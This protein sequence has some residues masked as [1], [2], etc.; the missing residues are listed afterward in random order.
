MRS[1]YSG[2]ILGSTW[3]PPSLFAAAR[4]I[5]FRVHLFSGPKTTQADPT[6]LHTNSLRIVSSFQRRLYR[7]GHISFFG[8]GAVNLMFYLTARFALS[9]STARDIASLGFI[10]GGL[11][12]P[13]VCFLVAHRAHCKNLF[14]VPVLCLVTAGALTVLKIIN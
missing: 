14:A 3:A 10:V 2:L 1:R 8:L 11:T 5:V 9:P 13:L 12:M 6:N 7:L 4:T